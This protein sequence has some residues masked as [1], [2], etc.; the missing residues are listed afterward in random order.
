MAGLIFLGLITLMVIT[1]IVMLLM[2]KGWKKTLLTFA[3][4]VV[5]MVLFNLYVNKTCGP[6]SKDVEIMTPQAEAISNYILK[7][8][9]PESLAE[10][11]GLP[12][13][14]EDC[15]WKEKNVEWCYFDVGEKKYRSELYFVN[16]K[17]GADIYI[18]TF[19]EKSET[20]ISFNLEQTNGVSEIQ[21]RK[22][23]SQKNDG[24]CNP[25]RQ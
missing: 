16:Y 13:P 4:F 17:N 24:I 19:N 5:V 25:L 11:P 9:I 8:G 3:G 23:Y 14:L 22:P 12:Y 2:R 6:D 18:D 21:Y 20:G 15:K 1:L 10:I 7:N